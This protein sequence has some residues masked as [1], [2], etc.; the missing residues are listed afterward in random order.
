M[1]SSLRPCPKS[2][3]R[4]GFPTLDRLSL[5]EPRRTC[6]LSQR[7]V[8]SGYKSDLPLCLSSAQHGSARLSS[9]CHRPSCILPHSSFG[10]F[11]GSSL[12]S[13]H[14]PPSSEVKQPGAAQSVSAHSALDSACFLTD[15]PQDIFVSVAVRLPH[16]HSASVQTYKG[17]EL[18]EFRTGTSWKVKNSD[19]PLPVTAFKIKVSFL[20]LRLLAS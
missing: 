17:I 2:D 13:L 18:E 12:S 7:T 10:S 20:Q 9:V 19:E 4:V 14:L 1:S 6:V 8:F 3:Q 11:L 16:I 15:R 5:S